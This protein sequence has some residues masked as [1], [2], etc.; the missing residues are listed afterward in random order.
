MPIFFIFF[1]LISL[2][3]TLFL[4]VLRR[5]VPSP[6]KLPCCIEPVGRGSQ[7]FPV[8]RKGLEPQVVVS[9]TSLIAT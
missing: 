9:V 4:R 5:S 7:E 2:F 1:D 6:S 8:L 3:Y